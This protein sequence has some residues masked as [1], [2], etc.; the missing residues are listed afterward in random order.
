MGGVG[1]GGQG[2]SS[3]GSGAGSQPEPPE[4]ICRAEARILVTPGPITVITA[5]RGPGSAEVNCCYS[6]K[7]IDWLRHSRNVS[8]NQ[9]SDR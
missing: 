9:T 1:G 3:P 4:R 5:S 7:L 6:V 8:L 2:R